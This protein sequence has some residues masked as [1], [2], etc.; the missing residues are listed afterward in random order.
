MEI[1]I[2]GQ[3]RIMKILITVLLILVILL[4]VLHVRS[5]SHNTYDELS[6]RRLNIIEEDG[7][8]RIV[9]SNTDLMPLP[10]LDGREYP[11]SVSPAGIV[12]YD[13]NGNE[14]GGIAVVNV[15]GI[16]KT[17]MIFDYSN[18][19]AVGFG[20]TES[21]DG[22]WDAG[23]TL[24]DKVPAEADIMEV[25]S[26]GTVRAE[27]AN[28]HF[29]VVFALKDTKG[30]DRILLSVDSADVAQIKLLDADGNVAFQAP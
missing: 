2:S 12:F 4:I 29:N 22:W 26:I 20:K 3:L 28:N 18:S 1:A 11:R 23:F 14:C 16:K 15:R 25:G 8:E 19:E 27:L 21:D 6:V 7:R 5:S 17:M 10:K 13:E 30:N 9:L 24:V